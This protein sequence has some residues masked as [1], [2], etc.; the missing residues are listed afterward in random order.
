MG[1][2][3]QGTPT[4]QHDGRQIVFMVIWEFSLRGQIGQHGVVLQQQRVSVGR[5]SDDVH[6]SDVARGTRPVLYRHGLSPLALQFAAN[7]AG[8]HVRAAAGAVGNHDPDAAGRK[9]LCQ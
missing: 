2:Q 6:A 5:C 4:Q 9:V 1:D 8:H 7:H 3:G